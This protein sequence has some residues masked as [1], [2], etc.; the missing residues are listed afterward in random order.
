MKNF[1]KCLFGLSLCTILCTPA[2]TFAQTGP[3][4][5]A[6]A[7]AVETE[8]AIPK[9]IHDGAAAAKIWNIRPKDKETTKALERRVSRM[10]DEMLENRAKL[11]YDTSYWRL[12][13]F[14][15]EVPWKKMTPSLR[16]WYLKNMPNR[17]LTTEQRQYVIDQALKTS[18]FKLSPKELDIYL[19]Y[20]Q[21]TEPDLR[22]RVV[23]LARQNLGQPYAIYLLGEFP[24]EIYDADPTFC[25][26]KGDCVVFSEHMYSMALGHD[27]SS[28]YSWLQR[29]RYKNG[30]P[31]MTTRNHFT[32]ADWDINNSWLV[33]DVTNE[34]GATTVTRYTEKIDRARFF[35]NFGI[36][37]DIPVQMLH[38]SY[39]PAE[40]IPS[41]LD[42]LQDGDFVNI[43][44][45]VGENGGVWVGH[46][47]LIAHGKDG[48][49]HF[50][51]ST[52][53]KAEE[54]PVMQY[55]ERNLKLNKKRRKDG[56]AEFKGMKFL[57]LRADDLQK[58][59]NDGKGP[60]SVPK[61][62]EGFQDPDNGT[63][64]DSNAD[65]AAQSASTSAT[66]NQ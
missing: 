48:K 55:V 26:T 13:A 35:S 47:G 61:T 7:H 12:L 43:V 57:R 32:E 22:K 14:L 37:Q 16:T 21:N 38:D 9:S 4:P 6:Q 59:L 19:G 24:H 10:L 45:G 60:D 11:D 34:L 36:G 54:E 39:I 66:A 5:L 15:R 2:A 65:T 42:K 50:I 27:W 51:N 33:K 17:R 64:A 29:I 58:M 52:E 1:I 49:A 41:V 28:F 30:V 23:R 18:L 8:A 20:M 25:L 62:P 40:A 63:A 53:P 3:G 44:R 46:V 31:G 56:R